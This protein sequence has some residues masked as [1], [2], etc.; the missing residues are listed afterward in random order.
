[1]LVTCNPFDLIIPPADGLPGRDLDNRIVL[2]LVLVLVLE[3]VAKWQSGE[4]AVDVG[5][6]DEG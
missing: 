3:R 1:M 6:K 5:M 2:V 4:G